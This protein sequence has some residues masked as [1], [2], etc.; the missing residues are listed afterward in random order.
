MFTDFVKAWKPRTNVD[1]YEIENGAIDHEVTLWRALRTAA[2]W[3]GKD[4]LDPGCGTAYW[5]PRYAKSTRTLYGVEPDTTLLEAA[6]SRMADAT[7][8]HGSAEC[9][10]LNDSSVDVIHARFAYFFPS[11]SNDCTAGLRETL[12][13]LRPGGSLIVIDNDQQDGDFA[14]LLRAG[15]TSEHQG[16]GDFILRWW[17][18]RGATTKKIMSSWTF[19]SPEDLAKVVAMEFPNNTADTWLDAHAQERT[20]VRLPRTHHQQS[21]P[22]PKTLPHSKCPVTDG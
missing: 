20:L 3:E 18:D 11:P 21:G 10:P 8:L 19:N 1:L 13:V 9:I 7:V 22:K 12:Q 4:L 6:A 17:Q 15:N 2:P 5:L 14:E 16:P